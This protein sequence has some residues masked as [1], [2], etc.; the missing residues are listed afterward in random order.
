MTIQPESVPA[1][2]CRECGYQ[3]TGLSEPRCPECGRPFEPA[4]PASFLTHPKGWIRRRWLRRVTLAAAGLLVLAGADLLCLYIPWQRE[5]AIATRVKQQG[6]AVEF[7]RARSSWVQVLIGPQFLYQRID[8]ISVS[9]RLSKFTDADL[10]EILSEV[11]ELRSLW[12]SEAA[13]TDVSL[14][15]IAR[16]PGLRELSLHEMRITDADLA[17]LGNLTSLE[18]L[19]LGCIQPHDRISDAGLAHLAGLTGLKELRLQSAGISDEG[20]AHLKTLTNLEKLE[21]LT[22]RRVRGPGLVYLRDLP[23]LASLDLR[24]TQVDDAGQ[25]NLANMSQLRWLG[26]SSLTT[27]VGVKHIATLSGLTG[28]DLSGTAITEASLDRIGSLAGLRT[29]HLYDTRISP[30]AVQ[31]LRQTLPRAHIT[32][33]G[34][35]VLS[36]QA[37]GR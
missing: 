14:D 27:D 21:L 18:L 7:R 30:K 6:G 26:A 29:L 37:Q 9:G 20:L 2:Y 1:M 32:G 5:Q 24:G 11:S 3:L 12:I 16:M 25:A 4:D 36:G 19:D 28:L 35:L 13:L 23:N 34:P 17:H 8:R 22:C 10:A 15:R 33:P 31:R